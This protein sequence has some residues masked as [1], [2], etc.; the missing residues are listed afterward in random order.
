MLLNKW[1]LIAEKHYVD[2]SGCLTMDEIARMLKERAQRKEMSYEEYEFSYLP[3]I[4]S[5]TERI[6]QRGI[7]ANLPQAYRYQAHYNVQQKFETAA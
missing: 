6:V 7:C 2:D 1:D 5:T 3:A 4:Q